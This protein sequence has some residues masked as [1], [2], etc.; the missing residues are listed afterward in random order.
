MMRRVLAITIIV[1]ALSGCSVA[2]NSDTPNG[3]V[4]NENGITYILTCIEGQ[5]FIATQGSYGFWQFAG[6]VNSTC[7][8][9]KGR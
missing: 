3:V 5:T 7:E 4:K 9:N 1:A 6:P 8:T 2:K